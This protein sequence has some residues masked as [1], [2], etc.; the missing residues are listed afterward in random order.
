MPTS[1]LLLK[2]LS[3]IISSIIGILLKK[4]SDSKPHL[5]AYV[6]HIS[7]FPQKAG[8]T[9]HIN[10][11][12][13][14]IKND[15][16]KPAVNVRIGHNFLPEYHMLYPRIDFKVSTTKSG[17]KEIIIERI[18][19]TEQV[20]ISYLYFTPLSYDAIHSY[21]KSDDGLFE[22][23]DKIPTR[24]ESPKS[25]LYVGRFLMFVGFS[26]IIYLIGKL[27]II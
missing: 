18:V 12:G 11:H 25:V 20:A 13:I 7:A 8:E 26:F 10:T 19:P 5:T 23:V 22:I 14:I 9:T 24:F 2:L 16:N 21:I 17:T 6:G 3:P 1:D 4:F 15:G 27:L